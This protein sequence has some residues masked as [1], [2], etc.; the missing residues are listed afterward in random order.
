M[1]QFVSELEQRVETKDDLPSRSHVEY[2]VPQL[3][4]AGRGPL[5][6]DEANLLRY[7]NVMLPSG[8]DPSDYLKAVM[9]WACVEDVQLPPEVGLPD[10]P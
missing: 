2:R 10:Q 7:F 3:A 8:S 6:K 9:K 4:K 1:N 5:S